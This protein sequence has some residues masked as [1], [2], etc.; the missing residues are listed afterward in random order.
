MTVQPIRSNPSFHDLDATKNIAAMETPFTAYG[1]E[2]QRNKKEWFEEPPVPRT[3]G[4]LS[5]TT[6][7][8]EF[9]Q[10]AEGGGSDGRH[11]D[12]P[13]GQSVLL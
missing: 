10:E 9:A 7:A 8:A 3:I 11:G 4:F 6:G 13:P 12:K 1:F 5:S 2:Q